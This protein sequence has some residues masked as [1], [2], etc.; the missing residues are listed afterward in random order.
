MSI[1]N[2][3]KV[4]KLVAMTVNT[5]LSIAADGKFDGQDLMPL[6]ALA[7]EAFNDLSSFKAAVEELKSLDAPAAEALVAELAADLAIPSPKVQALVKSV[8][9]FVPPVADLIAALKLP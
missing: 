4:V 9:A 7:Q 5:G 8:V 2:A 6:M 1:D 3:K